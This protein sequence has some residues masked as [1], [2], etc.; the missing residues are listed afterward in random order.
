MSPAHSTLE[1]QLFVIYIR[2]IV[3]RSH[4]LLHSKLPK[5]STLI[6]L[7]SIFNVVID[8][9]AQSVFKQLVYYT[10]KNPEIV[11]I[12]ADVFVCHQMEP[13]G[14]TKAVVP[15]S[16]VAAVAEWLR[17]RIVAGLV[18]SSSPVP[19]KTRRVGKRCTLNLSRAQTS[20]RW[21]GVIV[22]RGGASSGVVHIT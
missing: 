16:L 21:C 13:C 6:F 7:R 5:V 18:T 3:H 17:Y 11:V 14:A 8:F 4:D 2:Q 10:I 9:R 22:R 19:L 1:T 15:N 12:P 20:S